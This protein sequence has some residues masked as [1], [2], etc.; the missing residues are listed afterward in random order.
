MNSKRF[1]KFLGIFLLIVAGI[2]FI[3]SLI[4]RESFQSVFEGT[5]EAYGLMSLFLIVFLL[6]VIPQYISP[7]FVMFN[8]WII[9]LSL[10]GI[11]VVSV[12]SHIVASIFGFYL[13][14]KYGFKVVDKIYE[15]KTVDS[16]SKKMDLYGK[17]I[18]LVS[19]FF[20]IPYI[21]IIF[22]S[23]DLSWKNF[24]WYGIIPR[25]ISFIL[26]GIGIYFF[27]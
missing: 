1:F 4:F 22:G 6:E 13:G 14:K 10:L 18:V 2:F 24:T 5:V 25:G 27:M 17:W 12:I 20:P 16:I 21:P 7:H 8:A 26:L 11:T 3:V 19:G 9:G 23:L 15:E